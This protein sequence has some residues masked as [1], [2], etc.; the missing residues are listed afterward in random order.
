MNYS[1]EMWQETWKKLCDMAYYRK[2]VVSEIVTDGTYEELLQSKNIEEMSLDF[3]W[4]NYNSL[5]PLVINE[6]K[7]IFVPK[8]LFESLG[9]YAWFRYSFPNCRIDFWEMEMD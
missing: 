8:I 9:V 7:Y 3:Q 6:L 4:K 5:K 1:P 2:N